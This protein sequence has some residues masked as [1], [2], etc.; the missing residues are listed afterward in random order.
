MWSM[1]LVSS[2]MLVQA[3]PLTP[4]QSLQRAYGA[5]GS[6]MATAATPAHTGMVNAEPVYYVFNCS[7]GGYIITSADDAAAPVLGIVDRGE[8]DYDAL[9][10]GLK[11]RLDEYGSEIAYARISGQSYSSTRGDSQFAPVTPL[12]K[13]LWNQTAPYNADCPVYNNAVTAAGAVGTAMAQVM[14]YYKYPAM[15]QDSVRYNWKDSIMAC[16]LS[17]YAP[18]WSKMPYAISNATPAD[19]KNAVAD[20]IK[21]CGLACKTDWGAAS[22]AYSY[23]AARALVDNFKYAPSIS[24]ER[25]IY[26]TTEGWNEL[27]YNEV[28]SGRPVIYTG[29]GPSGWHTFICDGYLS[30]GLFHINW[31]WGGVSDGYFMLSALNPPTIGQAGGAGRYNS[32]EYAA[33]GIQPDYQGAEFTPCTGLE[34]TSVISYAYVNY[35]HKFSLTGRFGNYCY[36]DLEAKIG[37]EVTDE[38]GN[39]AYVGDDAVTLNM[40]TWY[41]TNGIS[42]GFADRY[43]VGTYKLRPVFKVKTASGDFSEWRYMRVP[44]SMPSEW[45][46]VAKIENGVYTAAVI[47]PTADPSL[48]ATNLK[49]LSTPATDMNCRIAATINNPGAYEAFKTVYV[50]VYDSVGTRV[51]LSPVN[52][53]SV[54]AKGSMELETVCK[55]TSTL[56]PGKYTMNLLSENVVGS[57]QYVD[58]CDKIALEI[59]SKPTSLKVEAVEIAIANANN[60]DPNHVTLNM[61]L[62]CTEGFYANY[63]TVW[64]KEKGGSSWLNNTKT[65]ILYLNPGDTVPM[66][67]VFCN[68]AAESKKEYQVSV[69]YVPASGSGFGTMSTVYYTVGDLSGVDAVEADG[70]F[71]ITPNP[72][73]NVASVSAPSH[74]RDI[75]VYDMQG[76]GRN[77]D[78]TCDGTSATLDVAALPAGV[79]L[80]TVKTDT[81][82]RTMRLIKK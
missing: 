75:A 39:K 5:S 18:D 54:P 14:R 68:P 64:T 72:A 41:T 11:Y 56:T 78:I 53:V 65:P 69:Y 13:T 50:A 6:R 80:V 52:Y 25:R 60:V 38:K 63:L 9:P 70:A 28:K 19:Q 30:D 59:K 27:L 10:D 40:W 82:T 7:D 57:K 16:D 77:I 12:I 34:T 49:V 81:A 20:L 37:Y 33:I 2:S 51:F 76:L 21:K 3:A 55:F 22:I 35:Q 61:K 58:I 31:G 73:D 17:T 29:T 44:A 62:V 32:N 8:F 45:T 42:T 36:R 67:F 47:Q 26:Y 23:I 24:M 48:T 15:A 46:F 79:Y 43:P 1:L 66:Q 4:S 74:I 71:A